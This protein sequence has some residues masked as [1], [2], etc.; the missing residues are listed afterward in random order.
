[1]LGYLAATS[2]STI[3]IATVAVCR[4]NAVAISS[5]SMISSGVAPYR[6]ALR[7][8]CFSPGW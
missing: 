8:C 2:L 1:M 3:G 4:L 6:S 5:T 7:M